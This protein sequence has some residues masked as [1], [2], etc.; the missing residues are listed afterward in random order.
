MNVLFLMNEFAEFGTVVAHAW[1]H[2]EIGSANK[3][4]IIILGFSDNA[5]G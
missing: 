1:Q 4:K 2:E 5:E 3:I